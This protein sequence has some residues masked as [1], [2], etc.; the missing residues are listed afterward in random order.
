MVAPDVGPT[1]DSTSPVRQPPWS[2]PGMLP[3]AVTAIHNQ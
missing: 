1:A 3:E 2:S